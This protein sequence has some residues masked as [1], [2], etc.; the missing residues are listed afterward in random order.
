MIKDILQMTTINDFKG[1]NARNLHQALK[2][3]RD[4]SNWIKSRLNSADFIEEQDFITVQ[5]SAISSPKLASKKK[6]EADI[7]AMTT[8]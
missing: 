5:N 6:L 3:R 2:V 4:F 1:I 8:F 7:I